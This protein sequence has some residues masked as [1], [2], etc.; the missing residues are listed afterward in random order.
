MKEKLLTEFIGTFFLFLIIS[1]SAVAGNAGELA[2][3]AIGIGLAGL[4]FA[5]GHRSAAH[6]NPAVTL[7]F[8]VSKNQPA[9]EIIPYI[10]AISAGA[11]SAALVA[12]L[13]Q[14][15]SFSA[16]QAEQ[17]G[18]HQSE[19]FS[20]VPALISEFL[21]TFALI[22]VILNV[23]LARGTANNGFYG[24]AIGFTVATG[25]FS[26]GSISG[27][28]FNPAVNLGLYLHNV[29]DLKLLLTYTL[30]QVLA[31]FLAAVIFKQLE[32]EHSD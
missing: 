20:L 16:I 18:L 5:S 27:A 28:S 1:L 8:F 29:L 14:S 31:A 9:K 30:I 4:I 10:L 11:L 19:N 6:F 21:F 7:A 25:A 12:Q 13:I 22:W 2:P 23:A 3:L 15:D 32:A 17:L 26:V 24:I